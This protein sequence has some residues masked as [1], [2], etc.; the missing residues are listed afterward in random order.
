MARDNAWSAS[1]TPV[2]AASRARVTSSTVL[3]P[4]STSRAWRSRSSAAREAARWARSR[5]CSMRVRR[6]SAGAGSGSGFSSRIVASMGRRGRPHRPMVRRSGQRCHLTVVVTYGRA[7]SGPG[8]PK[9]QG[10]GRLTWT[11]P[12]EVIM[13]TS[14][15]ASQPDEGWVERELLAMASRLDG[16]RN[17]G[18]DVSSVELVAELETAME[19]LRVTGE[20]VA[21]QQRHISDLLRENSL[22]QAAVQRLLTAMPMPV[23]VTDLHG[24]LVEAN[25]AAGRLLRVTPERL[26]GKP[27]AAYVDVA[28]RRAVRTMVLQAAEG[29]TPAPATVQMTPRGEG[30]QRATL[31][32]VPSP[33]GNSSAPP[34]TLRWFADVVAHG[35]VD[36]AD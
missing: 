18:T 34:T 19:E 10:G 16:L 22:A 23:L 13:E 1:L 9:A 28:D 32:A 26:R 31:I 2:A 15:H 35:D 36:G 8:M 7:R 24:A 27:L 3:A 20:E 14:L 5:A 17:Q 4:P 21:A 30:H 11:V 6:L 25:P 12:G 33:D 29:Q